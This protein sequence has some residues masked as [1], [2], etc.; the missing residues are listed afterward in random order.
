LAK[1]PITQ[2]I[3]AESIGRLVRTALINERALVGAA[4][5]IYVQQDRDISPLEPGL[6]QDNKFL[7]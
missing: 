3:V 4:A 5:A 1:Y 2:N 6:G 7:R